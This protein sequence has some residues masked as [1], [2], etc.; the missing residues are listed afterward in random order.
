MPGYWNS[1]SDI[2]VKNE[3][4]SQL[5]I[6]SLDFIGRFRKYP[7]G[8]TLFDNIRL[9]NFSPLPKIKS[10][11]DDKLAN[12]KVLVHLE[13]RKDLKNGAYYHFNG[14][15]IPQT[16]RLKH[17]NEFIF[18]VDNDSEIIE[19]KP[20]AKDFIDTI[21]ERFD[22][23]DSANNN[24][25]SKALNTITYQINKKPETFIY[26]LLQN[27]DD[28]AGNRDVN[29]TFYITDKYLLVFHNGEPFKFNN[30]FAICSV[31]AEDKSDDIDKIGFKGIGFKSVF[32]DNDWVFINSGEYSF[33][34]DQSIYSVEKPWQLMPIWTL[35]DENLEISIR[36]NDRFLSENVSIAL[37][38]K[39]NDAKLLSK[40][41]KTLE[42]F[43][44]DRILLFLKKVR[45][46]HVSLQNKEKI[47]CRKN[48]AIWDIRDYTIEVNTEIKTWLNEQI[49][50]NNQEVPIKYQDIGKFKISYAYKIKTGKV[51]PLVDS[52]LFNYLP[53]SISLGF[54]FLVN[55][56]FIPDGDREELYLNTWNEYLMIEIGKCIP[57]FISDIVSQRK[58]CLQLLPES[59]LNNFLN[60]KWNRLYEW[61]QKGYVESLIGK[62][63]IAFIP[64]KSGSLETLSNILIDETGLFE[65]LGDEFAQLTGISEK[66]IDSNEGEGIKKIKELINQH[67]VGVL[68]DVD[69]LKED[70]KTKL[71]NW[72][73][74]PSNNLK[75]IEHISS[76][77][78]LKGLLKTEE[79]VL[80]N[81][82]E[83]CKASDVFFEVPEEI[84]FL[85]PKQVSKEIL[86][87]IKDN[88]DKIEFKGFEPIQF[89]KD[90]I[91]G[92][93]LNINATLTYETNLLNFWKFIFDNW[94]LF[95]HENTIKDSLKHFEVLCKS[96]TEKELS[97]KVIS[98][99]YLSGEFN[100]ANEIES[101]V[102]EISPNEVFISDKY[103]DKKREAEK[104]SKIFKQAGAITDLQKV[105]EVLLPNL[106][107]IEPPKH[108]EIAKQIFKF[109]KDPANKLTESQIGLIKSSLKIKCVD[110]EFR[111]STDCFISDHY[112]NNQLIASWLPNIELVNQVAQE[113]ALRT[114]QVAEWK[115]FFAL[116]GCIELTDKQNVF[117]AKI[118]FIIASQDNL[119]EKHFEILKSISDLHKAKNNN[120][121]NFDFENVL[122]QIKLQ[123]SNDEWHLPNSIH[124][125]YS[126][127]PKL[128]LQN[129][130]S[131]N[132]TVLFLNDKYHPNEIDK[133]FLTE[134]G[135]NDS[136]KFYTSELKRNEIPTLYRQKFENKNSFIVRNA[137]LCGSQHR[138][139][140]HIDLNYKSLLSVYKY[141]EIF[142]T[143]VMKPNSRYIK[144][145]FQ[146][147]IYRTKFHSISFENFLVN[148]I[149]LNATLPNQEG[150]LKKPT[151]LFSF[152][153]SDYITDKNEL[154]KFDLSVIHFN[155]EQSKSL[156]DILGV[157][158]FLSPKHCIELLSRTES[159]I[160]HEQVT[161]L[162]IVKIL[163][164]Y[165]PID[166]EKAKLFLLNTNLEWKPLTKLFITKD[167]QFKIEPSQTLHEIFNPIADSIGIQELSEVNL[168]LNTKPP[169]P[170]VTDEI[171]TFFR[172]KAKFIAF[173]IDQLRWDEV[174]SNVIEH[175]SSF[176]FYE[177]DFI[178]KV[179]PSD[180][181][182]YEQILDFHYDEG[183]NEIFYKGVWKNNKNVIEFLYSQLQSEK[184]EFVWFDNIINRWA[185]KKIIE[186]LVDM[187]GSIPPDWTKD[188]EHGERAKTIKDILPD[189]S[190]E[191]K[192][193]I[194]KII[195]VS[196]DLDGQIDANTT[197]KIKT[198]KYLKATGDIS[199]IIDKGRYLQIDS[200]K[201]IVRSAQKGLL[202]LDLYD[203]GELNEVNVKIAV[204]TNSEVTIF[205][206]QD[207]LFN[208]CKPQNTFG[209]I[210][211]P[212]D[213]SLDD[214]NNLDDIKEKNKWHFVFIVNK[215]AEAAKS[216]EELL[217]LDD[218]NY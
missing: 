78:S 34:F 149:K 66:L 164:D 92:K 101:V 19:Y 108:L 50:N 123:T 114:S 4:I 10:N 74:Q 6:K 7:N 40:Y 77:E 118:D 5:S 116:F 183:K 117:D 85:S 150:I 143:E 79:I 147:S 171:E 96:N 158:T 189:A 112:N 133:Y 140:N 71:Q 53:L 94:S 141:S 179:F 41:S 113:Y 121:L 98:S 195:N 204:Y 90:K 125:S 73:K 58:D 22:K 166:N 102:K 206:S 36:N 2:E 168:V 146:E 174:E 155:N 124:L 215:D 167:E 16:L 172:S 196:R 111:K 126:Y 38:P 37:R 18:T 205:D 93:Q 208:F 87:S 134:I 187:F 211:M 12:A 145:L 33:R 95:E 132:S 11:K 180:D 175:L 17:N 31:N 209:V 14:K 160:S 32:K 193:Y 165:I 192:A 152:L 65:F 127:K 137:T 20:N 170:V 82:G 176:K 136:F 210:R 88:E 91:L 199:N 69:R 103:I 110:K 70:I 15:V 203:W 47:H 181:P 23:A 216:Y 182:I 26:E 60:S 63:P 46:V 24:D 156:E 107:T 217:N 163:S 44:D 144:Y 56:D 68:Y 28:N 80:T 142:W 100:S 177:V 129:D 51:V 25:I 84:S 213:Y 48:N 159:R 138:L 115:N 106:P 3:I 52:T 191:E 49:R 81:L 212:N 8:F 214:Y 198:I 1:K 54:P 83:L 105:I 61:F 169:K 64:T 120:G 27:A 190:E 62:N 162:Q 154:P 35:I 139:K 72:L 59:A 86:M 188:S 55:S 194:S 135:V 104:W 97:K 201:I 151:E 128:N 185:D 218:Y 178:A 57:K 13:N 42:L 184:I 76:N 9:P 197:A 153:L 207:G 186:T 99:A 39:E 173:K 30:V 89:F 21:Y 122:S 67:S 130:E 200:D 202:Y 148:Y 45:Q 109:W 29:V 131:L 43:N 75:F 157:Q 161:A 119:K